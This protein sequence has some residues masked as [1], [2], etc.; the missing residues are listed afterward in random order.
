MLCRVRL[1]DLLGLNAKMGTQYVF[2]GKLVFSEYVFNYGVKRSL[3]WLSGIL[4][5]RVNINFSCGVLAYF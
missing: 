5:H 1:S 2:G 3:S 4:E